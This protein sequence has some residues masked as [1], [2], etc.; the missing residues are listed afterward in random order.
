MLMRFQHAVE[1]GAQ[2]K[3]SPHA[4]AEISEDGMDAKRGN[5]WCASG[6]TEAHTLSGDP[7]VVSLLSVALR[8]P[9]VCVCV[10]AQAC[11][12]LAPSSPIS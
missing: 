8:F 10:C 5:S 2:C 4:K 3:Q 7:G 1:M 9:G 12:I 11:R 6:E